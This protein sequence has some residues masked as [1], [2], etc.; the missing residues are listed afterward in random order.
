MKLN[1]PNIVK[2]FEHFIDSQ[3]FCIVIEYIDG[4]LLSD[5]IY[6]H[7]T[8]SKL[9]KE[10]FILNVFAQ[11]TLALYEC[12]MNNIIHCAVKPENILITKECQSQTYRF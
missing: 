5:K 3:F 4:N 2:I 11:L 10:S 1:H 9:F 6:K 7:S 8:K 12:K